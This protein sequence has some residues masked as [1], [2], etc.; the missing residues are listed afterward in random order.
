MSRKRK[1]ERPSD[2]FCLF[3]R[4]FKVFLK[5]RSWDLSETWHEVEGQ[6]IVLKLTKPDFSGINLVSFI[7]GFF[8][9][10]LFL[11]NFL[12]SSLK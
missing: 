6:N 12:M 10:N 5:N 3:V 9:I 8:V 11:R 2:D 1:I 7:E 4:M